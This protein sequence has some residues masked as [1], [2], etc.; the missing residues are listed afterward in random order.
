MSGTV[1]ISWGVRA[2]VAFVVGVALGSA[3]G[4]LAAGEGGTAQPPAGEISIARSVADRLTNIEASLRDLQHPTFESQPTAGAQAHPLVESET[5]GAKKSLDEL[6]SRIGAIEKAVQDLLA[7]T[8]EA[9][10]NELL[11]SIKIP[12]QS[13]LIDQ[14][15]DRLAVDPTGVRDDHSTWTMSS[16]YRQY[17]TP[18]AMYDNGVRWVYLHKDAKGERHNVM[19][20]FQG[21]VVTSVGYE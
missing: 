11:S 3:A 14:L 6:S 2:A 7:W 10:P 4:Y 18:D 8:H 5:E 19:F 9:R 13:A 12:K 20:T 16:V 15:G 17:G 1:G 21:G